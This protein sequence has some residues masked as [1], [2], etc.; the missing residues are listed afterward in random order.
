MKMIATNKVEIYNDDNERIVLEESQEQR[1]ITDFEYKK[2]V[3]E[4]GETDYLVNLVKSGLEF[5]Y[6]FTDAEITV[7]INSTSGEERIINT[8]GVYI[9]SSQDI[10]SLYV[11]NA[12]ATVDANVT[13]VETNTLVS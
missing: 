8:G 9:F 6:I 4:A 2:T 3:V 5:I 1:S 11:T 10:D 12:S 13:V 7:K